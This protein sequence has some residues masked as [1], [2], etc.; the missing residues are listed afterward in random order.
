MSVEAVTSDLQ[1][2]GG[3]A[4]GRR[5]VQRGGVERG[6]GG[7]DGGPDVEQLGHLVPE[8]G[9]AQQAQVVD[10]AA[11]R[12]LAVDDVEDLL[13]DDRHAAAVVGV[14]D[15]LEHLAV[16]LAV[17]AEVPVEPDDRQDRAAVLH[18]LAVADP[19]HGLGAHLLEAGDGVQ[20]DGDPPAP[21]AR[22]PQPPPPRRPPPIAASSIRCRS[23]SAAAAW[24]AASRDSWRSVVSVR[25]A[26]RAS[27]WTS[28]M[29]A[30]APSPR[31]VAPEYSPIALSW[32]PT[33]LT[34]ISSVLITRST[35]S[36]KRRPSERRT[37]MT[38]W[39]SC[40]SDGRPSTSVS[41]TSGSS[42]PRSR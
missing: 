7:E 14:D 1:Q 20:R 32:P 16:G 6:I 2:R 26:R 5:G 25:S 41:R 9:G 21:A 24:A 38:T 27:A 22:G 18:D 4:V 40:R 15:D 42:S 30:T 19:L 37:A 29:R 12:R 10:V 3:D 8:D 36:P 33:A 34:T 13:H 28:R 11:D 17:C 35:T 31:T 39:P 23:V